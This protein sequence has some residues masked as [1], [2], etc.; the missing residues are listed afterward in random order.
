[1]LGA[2]CACARPGFFSCFPV[3]SH[4]AA[5]LM[6]YPRPANLMVA[7]PIFRQKG[8][9]A[10]SFFPC[11]SGWTMHVGALPRAF[12]LLLLRLPLPVSCFSHSP[13]LL[14]AGG[15]TFIDVIVSRLPVWSPVA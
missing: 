7:G 9:S 6:R 12:P 5:V 11:C 8:L 10:E 2:C 13:L 15:W 3:E 4:V 14:P 1:M